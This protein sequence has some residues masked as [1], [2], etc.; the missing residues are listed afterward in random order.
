MYHQSTTHINSL[1]TQYLQ[2][3]QGSSI[4]PSINSPLFTFRASQLGANIMHARNHY[5][6][7][8]AQLISTPSFSSDYLN[9]FDPFTII[10]LACPPGDINV[11]AK[12]VLFTLFHVCTTL[13]PAQY[14]SG[15]LFSPL[16]SQ[17][18]IKLWQCWW[19]LINHWPIE[20]TVSL[21]QINQYTLGWWV[22][23]YWPI[24]INCEGPDLLRTD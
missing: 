7:K 11:S 23:S 20:W 19:Q 9:C 18:H 12:K 6:G 14:W 1:N 22:S 8:L 24:V 15:H 10:I 21:N 4:R 17:L 13:A 5:R 3:S 2:T 16:G